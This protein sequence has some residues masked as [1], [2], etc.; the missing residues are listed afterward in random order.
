MNRIAT[1]FLLLLSILCISV[2]VYMLAG[3]YQ[4]DVK[5]DQTYEEIQKIFDQ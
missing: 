3:M 5:S 4:E 2:S 1:G